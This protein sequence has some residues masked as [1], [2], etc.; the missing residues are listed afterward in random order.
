MLVHG[1]I[2]LLG[3][4][5]EWSFAPT[6][7]LGERIHELSEK[8]PRTVGILWLIASSL[9]ISG[10]ILFAFE[11][12]YFW[13]T[14]VLGLVLSQSLIILYW[15]DAKFGTIANILVAILLVFAN[16]NVQFIQRSKTVTQTIISNTATEY[17]TI[18]QE[19]V[20]GLPEPVQRWMKRSNVIDRQCK[21]IVSVKQNGFLRS[22]VDADWMPFSAQQVFTVDPPAF[23]WTAKVK[24]SVLDI[25]AMDRY[26]NGRG[27]M[28]VKPLYIYTSADEAGPE[29]DQGSLVR[30][31]AEIQWFPQAAVSK[32][33]RWQ[34]LDQYHA[35]ATMSYMDASATGIYS[36]DKDGNI[37]AFEAERF[38]KF[39]GAYNKEKWLVSTTRF[40]VLNDVLTGTES[41]VTWKLKDGDFTWLKLEIT[42]IE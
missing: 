2:H 33:I 14:A 10:A 35:K 39:N 23:V 4:S 8:A 32:H 7:K 25:A 40:K 24:A 13:V 28:L 19:M 12:Q 29:I 1:L 38:G 34:P 17:I 18:T 27:N 22:S 6:E 42:S 3:F 16:A 30:Y 36:F 41:E 31:L 20:S 9:F 11:K 26:E 21:N 15:D 37:T 5:R